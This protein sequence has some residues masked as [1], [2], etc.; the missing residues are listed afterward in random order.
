M[1]DKQII[2]RLNVEYAVFLILSIGLYVLGECGVLPEGGLVGRSAAVYALQ[3]GTALLTI[4]LIPLALKSFHVALQRMGAQP[5][6]AQRRRSYVRWNEIRLAL[7]FVIIVV[8]LTAYY[9]TVSNL[10]FY[11]A[12]MALIASLFCIPSPKGIRA[13]LE[14][15]D[16]LAEEQEEEEPEADEHNAE[17]MTDD[18]QNADRQEA[19]ETTADEPEAAET[20]SKA[21]S[22]T[23]ENAQ[24]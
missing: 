5:D 1:T 12:V 21:V 7:F 3:C 18:E 19:E 4:V 15:I 11:C 10:G 14:M 13:E 24:E 16:A 9:A 2:R 17:E 23:A 6:A 20:E 8:A 22:Q